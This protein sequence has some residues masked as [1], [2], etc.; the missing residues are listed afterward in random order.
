[1]PQQARALRYQ[2]VNRHL[3][4]VYVSKPHT[5]LLQA[6]HYTYNYDQLLL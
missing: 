4:H 5:P 1:M 2:N 6:A 3:L